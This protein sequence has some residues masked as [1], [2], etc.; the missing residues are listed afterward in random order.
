MVKEMRV[1]FQLRNIKQARIVCGLQYEGKPCD[2]EVLYQFGPRK[3]ERR[4]KCPRC[5]EDWT[6][7]FDRSVPSDMRQISAQEA[8]SLNLL[9]ALDTLL[10]Q[11]GCAAF[12][13]RFEID[14]EQE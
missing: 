13:I 4:W 14:G 12:D 7:K 3:L 2:G 5:G 9:N 6:T 8:A 1:L 10:S 11:N